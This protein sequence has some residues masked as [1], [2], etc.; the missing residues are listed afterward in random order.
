[1]CEVTVRSSPGCKLKR[2]LLLAQHSQQRGLISAATGLH[3][4]EPSLSVSCRQQ[5]VLTVI[6]SNSLDEPSIGASLG[7]ELCGARVLLMLT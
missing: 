6:I 4:G 3:C 7:L 5:S 1:M 2:D